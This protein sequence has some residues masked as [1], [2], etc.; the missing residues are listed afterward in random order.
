MKNECMIVR[1][2]LPLYI[3]DLVSD[4]TRDIYGRASR[5]LRGLP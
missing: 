3:E 1:D 4:E 2:L 5:R